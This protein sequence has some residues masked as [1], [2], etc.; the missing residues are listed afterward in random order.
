MV[1]PKVIRKINTIDKIMMSKF[2]VLVF[3]EGYFKLHARR[4]NSNLIYCSGNFD[5]IIKY[6]QEDVNRELEFLV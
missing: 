5:N 2:I 6:P 4:T 3:F 1:P